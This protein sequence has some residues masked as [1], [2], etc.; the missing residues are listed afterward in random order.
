MPWPLWGRRRKKGSSPLLPYSS[1]SLCSPIHITI[2]LIE[3]NVGYIKAYEASSIFVIALGW[4]G[5]NC[6]FWYGFTLVLRFTNFNCKDALLCHYM[7]ELF[8]HIQNLLLSYYCEDSFR[9]NPQLLPWWQHYLPPAEPSF[10]QTHEVE[11]RSW[12]L[13][14][15]THQ[16]C[17]QTSQKELF[18]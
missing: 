3:P 15:I 5:V 16:L 11:T 13:L 9:I 2:T 6:V 17:T 8:T 10:Y 4:K 18:L 1:I 14:W 7:L 12:T